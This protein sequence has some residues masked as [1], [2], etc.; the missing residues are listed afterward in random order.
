MRISIAEYV[1]E[2]VSAV[3]ITQKFIT[4]NGKLQTVTRKCRGDLSEATGVAINGQ[5]IDMNVVVG[6]ISSDE[7]VD[8][9]NRLSKENC[10]K[11]DYKVVRKKKDIKEGVPYAYIWGFGNDDDHIGA[12]RPL[13]VSLSVA[14]PFARCE[15]DETEVEDFDEMED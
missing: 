7:V 14:S 12:F 9:L 5:G 13:S 6:N 8:L 10:V 2:V 3:A 1:S 15:D 11:L 4:M